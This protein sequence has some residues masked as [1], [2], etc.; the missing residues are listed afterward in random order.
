MHDSAQRQSAACGR[1]DQALG[2][3]RCGDV[4]EF[5]RDARSGHPQLRQGPLGRR[6]GSGAA[7]DHHVARAA[8]GQPAGGGEPDAAQAPG[9]DVGAVRTGGL[10]AG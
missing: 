2:D 6:R 7:V 9:D 4:A 3:A 8:K 10:P 1:R 5:H